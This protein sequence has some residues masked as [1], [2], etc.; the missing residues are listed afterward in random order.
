MRR[1]TTRYT[2]RSFV[3]MVDDAEQERCANALTGKGL[4]RD[5]AGTYVR[6]QLRISETVRAGY[7]SDY[8]ISMPCMPIVFGRK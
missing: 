3:A 5:E 4:T 7:G 8:L 6:N 1:I 2:D